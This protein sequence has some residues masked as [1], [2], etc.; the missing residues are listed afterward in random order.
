MC[1]VLSPAEQHK[2]PALAV[3]GDGN[4]VSA[5]AVEAR[6]DG[7]VKVVP[8]LIVSVSSPL[9][10]VRPAATVYTVPTRAARPGISGKAP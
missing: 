2:D 1:F 4:V 10:E 5:V 8:E 7:V 6:D 9:V 3:L